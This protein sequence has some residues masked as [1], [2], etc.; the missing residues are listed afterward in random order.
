MKAGYGPVHPLIRW[1]ANNIFVRITI[2]SII[3]S[4]DKN[5][6]TH[7]RHYV[8]HLTNR[9][10]AR[11]ATVQEAKVLW[12]RYMVECLFLNACLLA[13]TVLPI[14][15][16]MTGLDYLSGTYTESIPLAFLFGSRHSRLLAVATD[17]LL[18]FAT[19]Y[20]PP[21]AINRNLEAWISTSAL[22]RAF[23]V[24]LSKKVIVGSALLVIL[25]LGIFI[26][27]VVSYGVTEGSGRR[28]GKNRSARRH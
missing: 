12:K 26:R 4:M 13:I 27:V 18:F 15:F 2:N 1:L 25:V 16:V 11:Q 7:R 3:M 23:E 6:T 14:W 21:N 10:F 8:D 22:I 20:L 17:V 24:A 5:N 19:V 28:D 9:V